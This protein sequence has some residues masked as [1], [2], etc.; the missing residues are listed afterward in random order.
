MPELVTLPADAPV[1]TIVEV[2]TRDG[3]L[4]L[5]DVLTPA[6]VDQVLAETQPYI[7]ATRRGR[8]SFTGY[9][10][11][12]TGALVARSPACRQLVMNARVLES[13]NR[14]LEPFC[15]RIQLH[16][17]QIIRLEPG[18]PAQAIHRDRWAWGT[19]LKDVEPQFNTIWAI[20]DFT[21]ENGA[22]QVVPGS[23]R[24][25]DDREPRP[26]EI[27]QAVMS[28]GSVLLYTGSVFHAG[29][30]N[31]STESR[32]GINI[33]YTLAWLRQ[34]ENQ[35]LAC[36]PEIARDLAKPLQDLLGYT[37]GSYALGY[38]TPPLP[39]GAGPEIVGP[40][41]ALGRRGESGSAEEEGIGSAALRE[42]VVTD[43]DQA[44]VAASSRV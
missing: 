17:T 7:D 24:W 34:E 23:T 18:Q 22:T 39:P 15:K 12:R 40:E 27:A 43:I 38:Y 32:I 11:T 6:E 30:A 26:E 42:A 25:P 3:A 1:D 21:V 4:I 13:A 41:Y 29:G 31:R 33:T 36:P 35:Y 44:A 9:Q 20:T 37:V 19:Y 14:F 10:T 8:D 5:R 2:L 28:R 16:L